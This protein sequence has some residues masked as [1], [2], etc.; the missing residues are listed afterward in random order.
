MAKSGISAAFLLKDLGANV[1]LQDLKEKERLGDISY[2]ENKGIK[3]YSGKNPDEIIGGMDLAVVSPGIPTSLP[4]FEIAKKAGVKV[5]SEVELSYMV[6]PCPVIAIT[7]TNGKTTTTALTGEII[8][9]KYP[10]CAVVGNIGVP[11]SGEVLRLNKDDYVVAEIS[12]FQLETSYSFHPHI[13]AV[14]NITPDHLDR[15]KTVENYTRIKEKIFS[16]QDE[17]DFTVLNYDDP[18]TRNMALRTKAKVFFFSSGHKINEGIY[19]DNGNIMLKRHGKDRFILN[20]K[21][22]KIL[23]THN[24]ENV[25][26]SVAI[27]LCAGIDIDSII[28]VVKKFPGVEHRIEFVRSVDGVDYYNDSKGTNCDAAVRG[29]LAMVKPCVLI[30]G[31][32]DKGAEY[33]EWVEKFSGRVKHLVLVGATKDKIAEC[34]LKHGFNNFTKADTFEEAVVLSKNIA[35]SGECVLLSPACASWGMFSNYEERGNM[36]KEIVG[37]F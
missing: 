32:Y 15:H 23:G 9:E 25:M 1:T 21:E 17:N 24:Y 20:V 33:D 19:I 6:T 13:S 35:E 8:K 18:A 22:L 12:S 27:A 34:C 11:Y 37:N 14:L 3:I 4:F 2:I 36:F 29:I 30:G 7:G 31:G 26:A 28:E 5:I 10:S 16:N